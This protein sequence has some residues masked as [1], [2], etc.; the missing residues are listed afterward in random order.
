VKCFHVVVQGTQKVLMMGCNNFEDEA[1]IKWWWKC[2]KMNGMGGKFKDKNKLSNYQKLFS[3][4][5][6]SC[7]CFQNSR[8][9]MHMNLENAIENF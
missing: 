8:V 2:Q 5:I 1:L 7:V 6:R 9:H 3:F 4:A